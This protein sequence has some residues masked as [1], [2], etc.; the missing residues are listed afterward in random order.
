MSELFSS[1]DDLGDHVAVTGR[2]L[3]PTAEYP[4]LQITPG[5]LYYLRLSQK[6]LAK[7]E[8]GLRA[9]YHLE[10]SQRARLVAERIA[11]RPRP[12]NIDIKRLTPSIHHPS[13]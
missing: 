12:A 7:T 5:T 3:A 13:H 6:P 1:V 11:P 4:T 2:R 9:I 8:D 10:L